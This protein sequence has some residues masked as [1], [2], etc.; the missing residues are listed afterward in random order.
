MPRLRRKGEVTCNCPAYSFPHRFGGG[1]CNGWHIVEQCFDQRLQC[2]HCNLYSENGCD[3]L[4]GIESCRE[5]PS[6]IYF[7]AW[8]EIKMK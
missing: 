1:C 7:C 2:Q 6:V 3:V 8:H 5:C 4:N